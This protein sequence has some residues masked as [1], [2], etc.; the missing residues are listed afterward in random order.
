MVYHRIH[1]HEGPIFKLYLILAF[2]ALTKVTLAAPLLAFPVNS[3][4]PLVARANQQY[5]FTFAESTFS[6]NDQNLQYAIKDVP[7]WLNFDGDNRAFSGIPKV[8]DLGPVKFIL[9]ATDGSGSAS[10][11]VTFIV[12]RGPGPGLGA[13]ISEQLKAFGTTSGP[14]TLL[15]YPSSPLSLHLGFNTFTNT[16]PTTSYYA[17]GANNAP[18]PSWINFSPSDL[19]FSGTTPDVE[20]S[21][22]LSQEFEVYVTASDIAGFSAATVSF[23]IVIGHHQLTF[24]SQPLSI[25]ATPGEPV[26][27]EGLKTALTLDGKAVQP[28]DLKSLSFQG[29]KWLSFDESSMEISGIAPEDL[30]PQ[31]Y[32]MVAIDL[33]GD[34]ANTTI[35][36]S[37]N[38]ATNLFTNVIPSMNATIGEYFSHT[39]SRN[40]FPI[41]NTTVGMQMGNASSWL[42]FDS[43][44]LTLTGT[45]PPD[46]LP[47]TDVLNV[48]IAQGSE[49]STETVDLILVAGNSP[50]LSHSSTTQAVPSSTTT[51]S[52]TST[53]SSTSTGSLQSATS[54]SVS[55]NPSEDLSSDSLKVA[56]AVILPVIGV[57]AL[58][59]LI[60]FI[61]K[62][63]KIRRRTLRSGFR[64]R[65]SIL[66]RFRCPEV[67]IGEP[68][69]FAKGARPASRH[70]SLPRIDFQVPS[71]FIPLDRNRPSQPASPERAARARHRGTVQ[72]A[73]EDSPEDLGRTRFRGTAHDA[74]EASIF[75]LPSAN[76]E[77]SAPKTPVS[78]KSHKSPARLTTRGSKVSIQSPRV[79]HHP[80]R[81]TRAQFLTS[82]GRPPLYGLGHGRGDPLPGVMQDLLGNRRKSRFESRIDSGTGKDIQKPLSHGVNKATDLETVRSI[83]NAEQP[84]QEILVENS[85]W[86]SIGTSSEDSIPLASTNSKLRPNEEDSQDFTEVR[87]ILPY[88]PDSSGI[89]GSS[90]ETS[91]KRA[92]NL[93]GHR[94]VSKDGAVLSTSSLKRLSSWT[95]ELNPEDRSSALGFSAAPRGSL[96]A[97]RK[98]EMIQKGVGG[99]FHK[100]TI[101][102]SFQSANTLACDSRFDDPEEAGSSASAKDDEIFEDQPNEHGEKVWKKA[103]G[104]K[105]G[106]NGE[107]HGRLSMQRLSQFI[108]N[109]SEQP[110]SRELTLGT[111]ERKPKSVENDM[112]ANKGMPGSKSFK[113]TL[114]F[115]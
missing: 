5:H 112:D 77:I 1:Q 29:P 62:R 63:R 90:G 84:A 30:E 97:Q 113:G 67:I 96:S 108:S 18:L 9:T 46:L 48:T 19:S 35:S 79:S 3:Q 49:T 52:A 74:L 34:V 64:G 45:P 95:Y 81:Y 114:A 71:F 56:P 109:P 65:K 87:M 57:L 51:A 70:W 7:P 20:S 4:V 78:R 92:N 93:N 2:L 53:E 6:S 82:T 76:P 88:S 12:A 98:G 102:K 100:H 32:S 106:T 110:K 16:G 72:D 21:D 33:Y 68:A 101:L 91:K 25:N 99:A 54:T 69:D 104:G 23:H 59:F 61:K 22:E 43:S 89:S 44:S 15:F 10:D 26:H 38:I 94:V 75:G 42:D 86:S 28:S 105:F 11:A 107:G 13:P 103:V 83:S 85:N 58:L 115:P 31:S 41:G 55:N 47:Q 37:T 50:S 17:F 27:Y 111:A 24:A 66:S 36:I 40:L 73:F 80:S 39:F 14:D 60:W 8:E